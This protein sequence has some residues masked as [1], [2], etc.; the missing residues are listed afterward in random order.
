MSD[1]AVADS[2]EELRES[3]KREL[4]T[5]LSHL[6]SI[7]E[8]SP[9]VVMKL[10][11]ISHNDAWGLRE[12]I[13]TGSQMGEISVTEITEIMNMAKVARI[14]EEANPIRPTG[15]SGVT[16]PMG[17][18]SHTGGPMG[19]PGPPGPVIKDTQMQA[20]IDSLKADLQKVIAAVKL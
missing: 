7:L 1:Q 2:E 8:L 13:R 19:P 9:E 17:P 15:M 6:S 5:R 11:T 16:G 3:N 20:Q 14:M 4:I 10:I 12:I 18:Y